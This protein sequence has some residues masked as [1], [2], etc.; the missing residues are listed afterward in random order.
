V[1]KAGISTTGAEIENELLP[2]AKEFL[3]YRKKNR[4]WSNAYETV[5]YDMQDDHIYRTGLLVGERKEIY[6]LT[7]KALAR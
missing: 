4:L 3:A 1:Q 5:Q 2:L 7:E 6:G